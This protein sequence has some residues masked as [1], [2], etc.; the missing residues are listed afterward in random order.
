MSHVVGVC[1]I[2]YQYYCSY[3]TPTTHKY[4]RSVK[5][6]AA[7]HSIDGGYGSASTSSGHSSVGND[8]ADQVD[9]E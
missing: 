9:E 6:V 4:M 1:E 3:M 5:F 8:E 2:I 7:K